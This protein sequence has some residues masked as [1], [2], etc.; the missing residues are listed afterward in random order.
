MRV[1]LE[2]EFDRVDELEAIGK[3]T[4]ESFAVELDGL[5]ERVSDPAMDRYP[6]VIDP[7][8][9]GFDGDQTFAELDRQVRFQLMESIFDRLGVDPLNLDKHKVRTYRVDENVTAT[10][11]RTRELIRLQELVDTDGESIFAIGADQDI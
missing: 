11:Y 1:A 9:M 2:S 3:L 10:V 4:L 5:I 7:Y 8:N 6:M